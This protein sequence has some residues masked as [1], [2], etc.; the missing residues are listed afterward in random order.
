MSRVNRTKLSVVRYR[1]S[2]RFDCSWC[3]EDEVALSSEDD[4]IGGFGR[5]EPSSW[6]TALTCSLIESGGEG[7]RVDDGGIDNPFGCSEGEDGDDDRWFVLSLLDVD[8]AVGSVVV[9]G[10]WEE[11]DDPPS[12]D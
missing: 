11:D 9:E 6:Y 10:S 4:D 1:E 8:E 5:S 12:H 2:S 7:G 3:L